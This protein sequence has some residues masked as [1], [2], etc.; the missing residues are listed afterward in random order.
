IDAICFNQADLD[1]RGHQVQ[2]IKHIYS[3]AVRVLVWLREED[4]DS[5]LAM[6]TLKKWAEWSNAPDNMAEHERDS[7]NMLKRCCSLRTFF[8]YRSWLSRAWTFQE[9]TLASHG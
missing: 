2:L 6:S 7:E 5:R 3:D 4:E 1:E 8:F 9:I